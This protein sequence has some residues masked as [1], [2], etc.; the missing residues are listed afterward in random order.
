MMYKWR[1][2]IAFLLLAIYGIV[3]AHNVI[4]HHHHMD[5]G[6]KM[7]AVFCQEKT[8][9]DHHGSQDDHSHWFDNLEY[10]GHDCVSHQQGSEHHDACH[11]DVR[12][13]AAKLVDFSPFLVVNADFLLPLL[14]NELPQYEIDRT[15]PKFP[16][17]Y[18]YA[19]PLRAPPLYDSLA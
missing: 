18:N 7:S 17:G 5:I 12:P 9:H 11:F 13:V 6:V 2:N 1:S 10:S 3:F 14:K 15:P 16:E 8:G 19:V 4:P